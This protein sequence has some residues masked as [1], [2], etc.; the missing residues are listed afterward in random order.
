MTTDLDEN[1]I[2]YISIHFHWVFNVTYLTFAGRNKED[3]NRKRLKTS[4]GWNNTFSATAAGRFLRCAQAV[5]GNACENDSRNFRTL[6]KVD[7][8]LVNIIITSL[9]LFY[10]NIIFKHYHRFLVLN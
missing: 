6:L 9:Q 4:T 5:Q 3:W 8:L 10:K 1:Q 7:L 2:D